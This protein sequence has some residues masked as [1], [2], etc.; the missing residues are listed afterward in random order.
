MNLMS[1][2]VMPFKS[3]ITIL[4]RWLVRSFVLRFYNEM[5]NKTFEGYN[6]DYKTTNMAISNNINARKEKDL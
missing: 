5:F 2:E 6:D 4:A 3:D 1:S